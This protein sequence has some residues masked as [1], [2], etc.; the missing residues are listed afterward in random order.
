MM[1]NNKPG[2][3]DYMLAVMQQI[4]FRAA[5]EKEITNAEKEKLDKLNEETVTANYITSRKWEVMA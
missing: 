5:V 3:A 2:K 1:E 4:V